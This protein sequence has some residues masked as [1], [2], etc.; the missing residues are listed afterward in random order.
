MNRL[1]I[2][3]LIFF[4]AGCPLKYNRLAD[5][6]S[7]LYSEN[8]QQ[9]AER[10]K[11]CANFGRD[12]K[13]CQKILDRLNESNLPIVEALRREHEA[14][15]ELI[16]EESKKA[17]LIA[18]RNSKNPWDK[19]SLALEIQAG[20]IIEA[21]PNE[22]VKLI[23]QAFF[24]FGECAKQNEPPCMTQYAQMILYGIDN[25]APDEVKSAKEKALYWLKLSARYGNENSRRL[26]ISLQ[27]EIPTPDLSM[28]QLQKDAIYIAKQANEERIKAENEQK[29]YN[30]QMLNEARRANFIASMNAFFPRTVRCTTSSFG[31]YTYV[32]CY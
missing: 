5:F 28:E 3:L 14:E 12:S 26:L 2:I 8:Y 15:K 20:N 9:A 16:S 30:K 1:Y 19:L 10:L 17:R 13:Q 23:E 21:Y 11:R 25:L 7:S 32:N 22:D 6:N 18:L 29:Y 24:G 31:R 4:L 27:E